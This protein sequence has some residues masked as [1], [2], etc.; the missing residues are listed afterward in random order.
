MTQLY[1]FDRQKVVGDAGEEL[2]Q[3]FFSRWYEVRP[4]N[5]AAQRLGY[6]FEFVNRKTGD[7]KKVELKTDEAAKKNVFIE[8]ISKQTEPCANAHGKPQVD[9]YGWAITSVADI[10]LYYLVPHNQVFVVEMPVLRAA[11]PTYTRH[12]LSVAVR[13]DGYWTHGLLVP[14]PEFKQ[15]AKRVYTLPKR[16]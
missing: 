7:R 8:T 9:K 13:N 5:R 1:D 14:I 4:V 12:C 2:V 10:L 3:K 6:D 11:L 15:L 16:A